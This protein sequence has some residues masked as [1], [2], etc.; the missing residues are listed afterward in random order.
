MRKLLV[1]VIA[2]GGFVTAAGIAFSNNSSREP[3]VDLK[4][5]T[6]E[7]VHKRANVDG[8]AWSFGSF[9]NVAG[10]ICTSQQFPGMGTSG[11]CFTK[12]ALD[13]RGV[14]AFVGSRQRP[15]AAKSL[16][17]DNVWVDG[18]ASERVA[19]LQIVTMNCSVVPVS[20]GA[21]GSFLAVFGR[22]AARAGA[23]P[24]KLVGR[25]AAGDVVFQQVLNVGQPD[26]AREA[27]LAAP[28]PSAACAVG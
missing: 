25:S 11:A 15:S 19:S 12:D 10:R 21:D 14:M 17:W 3:L 20:L 23:L 2:L 28:A 8:E 4:R 26:N 18:F 24:Y 9:Q 5:A 1:L 16:T 13:D 22:N 7:Q 27:G 6:P